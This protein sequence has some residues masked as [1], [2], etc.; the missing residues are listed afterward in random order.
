MGVEEVGYEGEVKFRVSGDEGG[1][2]EEFAAV[3]FVGVVE[4]L[5]G[6]LMEIAGL[7][8]RAAT[9]LWC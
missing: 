9:E 1:G 5:L 7:E 8:G 3:E 2:G 4:N 6:S